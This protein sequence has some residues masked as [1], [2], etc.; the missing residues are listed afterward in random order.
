MVAGEIATTFGT[1]LTAS[2]GINLTSSLPLPVAFLGTSIF[3]NGSP[4][5]LF[6]VDNVNG[7][8]QINFQVP[9]EVEGQTS[10]AVVVANGQTTNP[11]IVVPVLAAQPGIFYYD[12]VGGH[13]GAILHSNFQLADSS[14]PAKSGEIVLI[15][16]TGLGAVN[17]PP[18]DGWPGNGQTTKS[19]PLVTI[20]GAPAM[21]SFS[22]LAPGF[23]G[24]YQ[25][26]AQVPSGVDP[27]NQSMSITINGA[28]S[29]SVLLPLQ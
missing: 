9:W 27:G 23:V 17:A 10:A 8:Q 13:F 22:G 5:P 28:V 4:V 6:A 24:L 19:I 12:A 21:V 26:N 29:N 18:A 11:S 16:C 14:H 20:G 25:I 3:V 15:Y 2:T 1:H 7:Q